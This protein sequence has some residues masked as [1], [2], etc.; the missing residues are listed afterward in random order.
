ARISKVCT[1]GGLLL[2]VAI[3]QSSMGKA[4]AL[5]DDGWLAF[6]DLRG[7]IEPCGCDPSTDL[8]GLRRLAVLL[9]GGAGMPPGF[10]PM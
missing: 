2:V 3:C 6:G 4:A 7:Y 5:D 10:A 8:G 1:S 9:R